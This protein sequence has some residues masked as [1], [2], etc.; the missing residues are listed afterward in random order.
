MELETIPG[1]VFTESFLKEHLRPDSTPEDILDFAAGIV[2][3]LV[4]A[5][6]AEDL[7]LM[8]GTLAVMAGC[9]DPEFVKLVMQELVILVVLATG[10]AGRLTQTS[11]REAWV[12]VMEMYGIAVDQRKGVRGKESV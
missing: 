8:S 9:W 1:T 7:E 3:Q 10:S 11:H 2:Q 4:G 5:Y 12:A 6:L